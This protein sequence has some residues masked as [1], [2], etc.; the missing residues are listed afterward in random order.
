MDTV[1]LGNAPINSPVFTG[2]PQCPTAAA[3]ANDLQL[4]NTAH[5]KAAAAAHGTWQTPSLLSGW[6]ASTAVQYRLL[7]N[8]MLQIKGSVTFNGSLGT[9]SN[10]L[11]LPVGFR[12]SQ[13]HILSYDYQGSTLF[14]VTSFAD[15]TISHTATAGLSFAAYS[16]NTILP[17]N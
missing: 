4:A 6:V 7:S 8:N 13:N 11:I 3:S 14:Y 15:G 12:P 10:I 5:V 1:R 17:L 9:A 2:T 16:L